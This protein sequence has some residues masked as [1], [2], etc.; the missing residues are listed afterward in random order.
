MQVPWKVDSLNQ[1]QDMVQSGYKPDFSDRCLICGAKNCAAFNGSYKRS[2]IDPLNNIYIEDFKVLQYICH[3][4]G[5]NPVSTHITFS[6]LPWMLI[7]Y[8]R[9][10]LLFIIFSIKLKLKKKISYFNVVTEL[11][12]IFNKFHEQFDLNDF[13]N[14]NTLFFFKTI[15]TSALNQFIESGICIVDNNLYRSILN[16]NDD[17]LLCFI[18]I[19]INYQC[20][21]NGQTISGPIAFAWIFYQNS[22]GVQNNAPFLF[23]TASQHRV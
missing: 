8:H 11:D 15:I 16:N 6:L 4:K 5:C 20:E 19:L 14:A 10:P 18:N 7:P 13:I 1:Y 9:L 23:G 21:Y 22:G 2:V 12:S 3:R 17:S